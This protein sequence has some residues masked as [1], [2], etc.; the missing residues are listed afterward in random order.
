MAGFTGLDYASV[1]PLIDRMQ[2]DPREWDELFDDV[3]AMEAAALE[4]MRENAPQH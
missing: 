1:Y 2:L 3:R 4:Q